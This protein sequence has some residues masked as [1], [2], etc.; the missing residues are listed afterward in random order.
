MESGDSSSSSREISYIMK[1]QKEVDLPQSQ[2]PTTQAVVYIQS[3][4]AGRDFPSSTQGRPQD[5][6]HNVYAC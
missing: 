5:L 1:P 4:T 3:L 2:Q 6:I